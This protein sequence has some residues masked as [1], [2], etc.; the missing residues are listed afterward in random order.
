MLN[1]NIGGTMFGPLEANSYTMK[2]LR[3]ISMALVLLGLVASGCKSMSR[4]QKGA[5][6][7]AAGG[8]AIGAVIGRAAGNTAMGAIIGAAVGGTAGAIIG[9]KMDKQAEEM[10]EVLGDAEVRREGEGIV[11]VFK[12]QVLFGFDRSD[13][14]AQARTNLDKLNNVLKKY[15]DTDILILGHTDSKGSDTYNQDLSQRRASSVATYLNGTGI[16]NSR[17][18]TKGM[19]END[20]IATNDTEEG[21]SLN[22]RVE[23]VITANA[24]MKAEAE[25]ESGN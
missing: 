4:S 5:V 22:R 9:R 12:E 20:P 14:S 13:L 1:P 25:R 16:V 23:F 11:V 8:G 2:K 17:I 24:K 19:G 3:Q 7:G 6:I 15:P 10:K 18:S 21:R